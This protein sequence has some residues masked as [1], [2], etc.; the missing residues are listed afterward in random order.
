MEGLV[1]GWGGGVETFNNGFAYYLSGVWY[2]HTAS[3]R[4]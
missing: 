3:I 1:Q 4:I 2:D